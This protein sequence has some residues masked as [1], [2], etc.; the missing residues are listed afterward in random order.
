M[1]NP[2]GPWWVTGLSCAASITSLANRDRSKSRII[3]M[4]IIC[5][6]HSLNDIALNTA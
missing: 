6:L 3:K 1:E 2:R 5:D 4:M